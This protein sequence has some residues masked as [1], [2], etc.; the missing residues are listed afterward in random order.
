MQKAKF[1][2]EMEIEVGYEE[3]EGLATTP[4]TSAGCLI[5]NPTSVVVVL[6]NGSI[7]NA[8]IKKFEREE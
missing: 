3:V 2:I 7:Q 1:K 5:D 8:E 6:D 4:Y